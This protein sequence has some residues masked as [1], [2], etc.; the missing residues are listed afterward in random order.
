MIVLCSTCGR[1]PQ[2]HSD[3]EVKS[4][5]E[6]QEKH[7]FQLWPE[8]FEPSNDG[9][10]SFL[11]RGKSALRRSVLTSRSSIIGGADIESNGSIVVTV[12]SNDSKW[13]G[14]NP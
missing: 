1:R 2:E 4:H 13:E 12:I 10:D 11:S 7:R 6:S 3:D 5:E 9:F 8:E 14:R